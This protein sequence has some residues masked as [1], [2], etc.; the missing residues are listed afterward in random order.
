MG[1]FSNKKKIT[2][3]TTVLRVIED[4]MVPDTGKNAVLQALVSGE[5]IFGSYK[6]SMMDSVA[7]K[8]GRM[9]KWAQPNY[10]YKVPNKTLFTNVKGNDVVKRVIEGLENKPITVDYCEYS[11][12]NSLHMGWDNLVKFHG[13][14]TSTN[15]LNKLTKELGV[16]V[17]L[18]DMRAVY[19]QETFAEA[20]PGTLAQWGSPATFGFSFDRTAQIPGSSIGDYRTQSNYVV[21]SSAVLDYVEVSYVHENTDERKEGVKWEPIKKGRFTISLFQYEMSDEYYHVKY[22]VR[23]AKTGSLETKYW[24]YKDGSGL[25]PIIDTIYLIK[26]DEVGSFMPNIYFLLNGDNLTR[27]EERWYAPHISSTKLCKFLGLDY[28]DIGSKILGEA[29]SADYEQV[30]LTMSVPYNTKNQA[31]LQYLFKFFSTIYYTSDS[32]SGI[33]TFFSPFTKRGG[34]AIVIKDKAYTSTLKFQGIE[35]NRIA[36][37]IGKVGFCT[38]GTREL[39]SLETYTSRNKLTDVIKS[40]YNTTPCRFFRRQVSSTFYE[41]IAV[42]GASFTYHVYGKYHTVATGTDSKLLVPLDHAICKTLSAGNKEELYSRSMHYVFNKKTVT[43]K[44][45]YTSSV[46]KAIVI[47]VAV[48]IAVVSAGGLSGISAS[49]ATLATTSMAVLA[50]MAI[51]YVTIALLIRFGTQFVVSKIGAKAGMLA[52]ILVVAASIYFSGPVD[53]GAMNWGQSL[54]SVGNGLMDAS[55]AAISEMSAGV[56]EM[57]EDFMLVVD[58]Q[59]KELQEAQKLLGSGIGINPYDFVGKHPIFIEGEQPDQYFTRTVE[60]GNIGIM[61]IEGQKYYVENAL[62]LPTFTETIDMVMRDEDVLT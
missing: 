40:K 37:K 7:M 47:V 45:W 38:S 13:Y 17:Y 56:N 53:P 22:S 2:V 58:Q 62:A 42:Y 6:E 25:Y 19:T 15:V 32:K 23:N 39:E 4:N 21:D 60:S 14:D 29:A 24:T 20:D 33:D 48:V 44:K 5:S 54:L 9:Y 11:A 16:T 27:K 59:Q 31:E 50:V 35:L 3:E 10:F 49:L 43:V 51:K 34:Q 18:E 28:Q 26:F 55:N 41:E 36:G 52:A 46:F 1:L 30:Y 61:G 57:M 8:V 12:P